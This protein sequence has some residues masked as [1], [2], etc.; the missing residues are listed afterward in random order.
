MEATINR[1]T[2]FNVIYKDGKTMV[3]CLQIDLFAIEHN[4]DSGELERV[5]WIPGTDNPAHFL[6]K[7]VLSTSSPLYCMMVTDRFQPSPQVW[8]T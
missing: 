6:R 8:A 4:Y 5:S 2:V 7:T 1:T 3:R